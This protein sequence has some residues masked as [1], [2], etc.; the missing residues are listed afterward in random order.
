MAEELREAGLRVT[1]GRIAL[2]QTVRDGDHLGAEAIADGVRGRIGHVSLQ[3][4]YE[5]L[6]ALVA[7]GLVRRLEPGGWPARF[8][9]RVGD[10]HHHLVCRAC[11]ALADVDRLAGRA[12]CLT[13]AE[14]HGF[15][16]E[17]AEVFFWGLCP[18]CSPARGS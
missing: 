15:S 2:L 3:T 11:G 13:A 8:D 1:A 12:S 17:E 18:A 4:V 6:Q 16:I 14:D 10:G 7:A 9:G 5:G